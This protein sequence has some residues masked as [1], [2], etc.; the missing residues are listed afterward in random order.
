MSEETRIRAKDNDLGA[1]H[2]EYIEHLR[3][4]ISGQKEDTL[5]AQ[6]H[7]AVRNILK[8]NGITVEPDVPEEAKH[9]KTFE[10]ALVGR[11]VEDDDVFVKVK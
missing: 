10:L 6:L 11:E 1:I 4:C 2:K 7:T 3:A 8:D 9:R 5:T